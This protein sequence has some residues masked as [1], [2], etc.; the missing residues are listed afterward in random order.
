M[1][2]QGLSKKLVMQHGKIYEECLTQIRS[3]NNKIKT[4]IHSKV[5]LSGKATRAFFDEFFFVWF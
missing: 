1:R 3:D 4:L 5:P 2:P